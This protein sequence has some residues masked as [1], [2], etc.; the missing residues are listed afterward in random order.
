M[1]K[2]YFRPKT[3]IEALETLRA[4]KQALALSG[5]TYLLGSRFR[6][7]S[8][9]LVAILGLLPRKIEL[10]G[11]TLTIGAGTTF[12][13]ILDSPLSPPVL[14]SAVLGMADRNIRNRAT[15]GG[16]I[17]ADK[18]CASLAPLF[19]AACARYRLA[20][21]GTVPAEIWHG[22]AHHQNHEIIEYVEIDFPH[23]KLFAYGKYSRTSCDLAVITCAVCAYPGSGGEYQDIKTALGGLSL[24]PRLFLEAETLVPLSDLRGSSD[25]K[26][27]RAGI[28]LAEV[29]ASLARQS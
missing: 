27:R 21:G 26:R 1:V 25:F 2:Q 15:V 8:M 17:G 23:D 9:S 29:R 19:L 20:G 18:S 4:D 5:G 6:D 14:K 13:E 12:Q 28:L 11:H 24:H 10:H 22:A 7:A 3:L 16:N